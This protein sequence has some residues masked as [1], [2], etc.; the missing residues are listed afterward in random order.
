[1][2]F[3]MICDTYPRNKKKTIWDYYYSSAWFYIRG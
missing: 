2:G 1:M 3:G